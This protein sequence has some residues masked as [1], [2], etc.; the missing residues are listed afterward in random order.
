MQPPASVYVF[1]YIVNFI[2]I[3]CL[4]KYN[5]AVKLRDPEQ[6]GHHRACVQKYDPYNS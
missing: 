1:V 2:C 4:L 5:T 6:A 3:S